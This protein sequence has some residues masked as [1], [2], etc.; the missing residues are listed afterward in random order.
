MSDQPGRTVRDLFPDGELRRADFAI[1]VRH[2]A[3][4]NDRGSGGDK[5]DEN[6]RLFEVAISSET[7]IERWFGVEVLDHS[8]GAVDL[9]R[10]GNGAAVLV[11]HRGDQVGVVEPCSARVDHDLVLRARIRF[12]RSTR[13]QEIEQDVTDGI[14]RSVSVGYFIR[15]AKLVET[16]K[17]AGRERT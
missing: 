8:R 6:E 3:P 10:L 2:V 7:E 16:R 1:E 13:G 17:V 12:S 4:T 15:D 14:R 9:T 11:D 5:S